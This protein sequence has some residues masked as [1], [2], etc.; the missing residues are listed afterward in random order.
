MKFLLFIMVTLSS[1][2]AKSAPKADPITPVVLESFQTTFR[3]ANEV[4]WTESKYFFKA[5]FLFNGQYISAFFTKGGLLIAT[6]KNLVFNE[7]PLF[8]QINFRESYNDYWITD[9]FEMTKD[10]ETTYYMTLENADQKLVLNSSLNCWNV[11][12]RKN[13]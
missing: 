5:E 9:L 6:A 1:F 13:K 8:L 12:D 10:G 11:F 7:L 3:E 4:N 2:A